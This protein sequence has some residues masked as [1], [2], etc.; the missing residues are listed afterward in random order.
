MNKLFTWSLATVVV[1]NVAMSFRLN[2]QIDEASSFVLEQQLE[3]GKMH[4]AIADARSSKAL[5]DFAIEHGFTSPIRIIMPPADIYLGVVPDDAV[6]FDPVERWGSAFDYLKECA[7]LED[8]LLYCDSLAIVPRIVGTWAAPTT[9]GVRF[10]ESCHLTMLLNQPNLEAEEPR[11]AFSVKCDG[12]EFE[13]YTDDTITITEAAAIFDRWGIDWG[14][15]ELE[16]VPFEVLEQVTREALR[17]I[18]LDTFLNATESAELVP[19]SL[20]AE[21]TGTDE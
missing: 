4:R 6:P 13:M 8:G 11:A 3:V 12:V 1:L 18:T 20:G 9:S 15:E 19:G 5:W 2:G 17:D 7:E 21:I 14:F 10:A 16:Y